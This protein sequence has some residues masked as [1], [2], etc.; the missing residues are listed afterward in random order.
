MN[1]AYL[2]QIF[3]KHY[4]VSF[5]DYLNQIRIDEAIRLL[6]RTDFR[7]YEIATKVGYRDSDYFINRFEKIMGGRLP[8]IEKG[9]NDAIFGFT[10]L[11]AL[12]G[13]GFL[14]I[15]NYWDEVYNLSR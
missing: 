13:A 5:S 15:W 9:T 11:H 7:V 10:I 12:K 14:H 3:K 6:R 8:S 2:G 4:G 1:S